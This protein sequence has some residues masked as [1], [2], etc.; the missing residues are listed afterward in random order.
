MKQI[1]KNSLSRNVLSSIIVMIG[2]CVLWYI[3]FACYLILAPILMALFAKLIHTEM[4]WHRFSLIMNSLFVLFIGLVCFFVFR[5]KTKSLFE[6]TF[7]TIPIGAAL[8]GIGIL[9]YRLPVVQYV[10]GAL[11]IFSVFYYF[12]RNK[13]SWLYYYSV[14]ITSLV[15]VIFNILIRR[16]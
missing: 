5:K 15:L 7:L 16:R 8:I 2:G 1:S 14:I 13:R 4:G 12:Y 3:I 9:F 11:F 10:L 6:A